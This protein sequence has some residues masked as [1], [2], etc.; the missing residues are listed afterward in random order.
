MAGPSEDGPASVRLGERLEVTL[1]LMP[2][3]QESALEFPF[4]VSHGDLRKALSGYHLRFEI[5]RSGNPPV[6]NTLGVVDVDEDVGVNGATLSREQRQ[7]LLDE[8]LVIDSGH[9]RLLL[10]SSW[11]PQAAAVIS[12]VAAILAL[13][14]KS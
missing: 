10:P 1:Y 6:E 11:K 13:F 2:K 12:L 7:F 3:D 14:V 5:R 9:W 4:K 8:S